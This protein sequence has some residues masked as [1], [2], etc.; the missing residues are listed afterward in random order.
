[1]TAQLGTNIAH[2][3]SNMGGEAIFNKGKILYSR[4]A[5]HSAGGG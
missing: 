2:R 1:M 4:F 3:V 5:R